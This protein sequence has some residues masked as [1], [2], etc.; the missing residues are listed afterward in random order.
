MGFFS[1]K[2]I[3]T[4]RS[5]TN[6]YS[7]RGTFTV[8]MVDDKGNSW[9]EKNYGGYGEFGGKDFYELL[10][11]MNGKEGRDAGIDLQIEAEKD[12]ALDQL[13]MPLLY[14]GENGIWKLELFNERCEEQGYF[15]EEE[16]KW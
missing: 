8:Y 9:R 3:D 15:Y 6:R 4:D 1:W 10:A 11:E 13:K 14:E 7:S 16:M 12:N 2:T 5:I